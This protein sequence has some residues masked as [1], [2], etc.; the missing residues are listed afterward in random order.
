MIKEKCLSRALKMPS[1]LSKTMDMTEMEVIT[2]TNLSEIAKREHAY[3]YIDVILTDSMIASG[4]G[5]AG[6]NSAVGVS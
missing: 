4:Q 5:H 3:S 1:V 2:S 6:T